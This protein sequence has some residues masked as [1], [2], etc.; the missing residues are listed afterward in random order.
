MK[1][2]VIL[3][4][5]QGSRFQQIGFSKPKGFIEV[6]N[7]TIIKRSINIL[8][9]NGINRIIIGTGY[10][11]VFYEQFERNKN[12]VCIKN[13]RFETTG[14]FFTLYNLR[15]VIDDNFLLLDSDIIYEERLIKTIIRDKNKNVIIGSN[16]SNSGD[17]V[18]I[19]KDDECLLKNLSKNK[20]KLSHVDS[21]FVGISKISK[22]SFE[23]ICRYY[24]KSTKN[25]YKIEY[26]E[27]LVKMCSICKVYVNK[28]S[29][30]IWSEI[31]TVDH[32]NNVIKNIYPRLKQNEN[33]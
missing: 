23:K 27:V 33:P 26:E 2:A 10:L 8:L 31:D 19:E 16:I 6:N 9:N 7:Q 24:Q 13:E 3:A 14:S 15:N 21:E 22:S 12:I 30:L 32:L 25:I 11:S 28:I 18:Y 20:T 29:N 1:V 4:A 17:E 5:G